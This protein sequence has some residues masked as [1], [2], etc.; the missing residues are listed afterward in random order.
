MRILFLSQ[1]L[2]LPLDAGPKMLKYLAEAGHDGTLV[3][4]VRLFSDFLLDYTQSEI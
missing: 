4:F 1:L 2:P 3:C